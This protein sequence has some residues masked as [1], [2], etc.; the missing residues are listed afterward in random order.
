MRKLL[1]ILVLVLGC[2]RLQAQENTVTD[3]SKSED[4]D[5]PINHYQTPVVQNPMATSDYSHLADSLAYR[6]NYI[7]GPWSGA[8]MWNMHTGL[9]VSLGAS[10]FSSLGKSRYGGTG[11]AQNITAVYLMPLSNKLSLAV[12][13]YFDNINWGHRSFRDAG[14]NAV[15]GYRFNEHW[16][17]FIYGQKSLINNKEMP[18]PYYYMNNVGDRI[19]AAVRYSPNQTF[20]VTVSVEG[21]SEPS[22]VPSYPFGGGPNDFPYSGMDW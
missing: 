5:M 18:I 3:F 8:G 19:G 17:A 13:G 22:W 1:F 7:L 9:N 20:S 2:L 6:Y 21:R 12:G 15:L 4:H 16:E 11:F 14:L 10:V